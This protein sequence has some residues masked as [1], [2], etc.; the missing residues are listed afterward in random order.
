MAIAW[1]DI[2]R[3]TN[4]IHQVPQEGDVWRMNFG[5]INKSGSGDDANSIWSPTK[6]WFHCP[7]VFGRIVFVN[8]ESGAPPADA[9]AQPAAAEPAK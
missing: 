8:G 5:R 4:V 7:W 9:A 1:T 3:G 6:G 2:A